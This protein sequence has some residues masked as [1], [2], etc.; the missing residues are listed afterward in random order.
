[1]LFEKAAVLTC[2]AVKHVATGDEPLYVSVAVQLE[3]ECGKIQ[4]VVHAS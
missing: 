1:M 3:R 2:L 4:A